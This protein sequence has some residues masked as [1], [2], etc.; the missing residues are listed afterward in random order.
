M[1]EDAPPP[2]AAVVANARDTAASPIV[3]VNLWLDRVVASEAFIGLPG[4]TMQWV[5]DKRLLFGDQASHLSLVSSGAEAIVGLSNEELIALAAGRGQGGAAGG[6]RCHGS[7]RGRRPR[8]ARDV[9]RGARPA[10][11]AGSEQAFPGCFSPATGSIPGCP[12]RSRAL[13]SADT[14]RLMADASRWRSQ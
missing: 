3:T 8:E 2:L 9:L 10:A 7:P 11:Q 12:L 14:G 6:R 13:S 1:L 4:R 5:F